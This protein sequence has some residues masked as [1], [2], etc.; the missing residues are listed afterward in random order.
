MVEIPIEDEEGAPATSD[1]ANGP[2]VEQIE[3][4]LA[5]PEY[6]LFRAAADSIDFWAT[7]GEATPATLFVPTNAAF[8]LL[9]RGAARQLIDTPERLRRVL[10][11]HL[12]PR[13]F[14]PSQLADSGGAMTALRLP[15]PFTA[16]QQNVYAAYATVDLAAVRFVEA[17]LT[18][19]VAIYPVDAVLLPPD[20]SMLDV[21][22]EHPDLET[23]RDLVGLAGLEDAL[24]EQEGLTLL[25][26]S[27][28]AFARLPDGVL[29][30]LLANPVALLDILQ[31]HL[32]TGW[33]LLGDLRGLP[34]LTMLD[35]QEVLLSPSGDSVTVARL[36]D[37]VEANNIATNGAIHV[38]DRV[39]L[40]QGE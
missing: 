17:D 38:I 1:R 32:T 4:E 35:G 11:Y 5:G 10:E 37:V 14:A 8:D 24:A 3:V 28:D 19:S 16:D 39:I 20:R 30:G 34:M 40:P 23:L 12:V 22:S 36:A 29:D 9:P 21:L 15:L 33:S 31:H 18:E 25:A 27:D 26:P 2:L 6:T 13:L 7:L